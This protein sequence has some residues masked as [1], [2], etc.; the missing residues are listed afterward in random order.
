MNAADDPASPF[1]LVL[2]LV[3]CARLAL[4]EPP[5]YGSFRLV[6]AAARTIEALPAGGDDV[7][8]RVR[9]SVEEHKLLMIDR[10][11]AYRQWLDGLL[12]EL[13]AEALRRG[14]RG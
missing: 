10:R 14:Q 13:T 11:D 4:D 6:E 1:E 5:I 8:R 9:D 7:L 2:Y 12:R 3:A